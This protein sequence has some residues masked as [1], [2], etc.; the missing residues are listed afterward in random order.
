MCTTFELTTGRPDL[1]WSQVEIIIQQDLRTGA[2]ATGTTDSANPLGA[3]FSLITHERGEIPFSAYDRTITTPLPPQTEIAVYFSK[4]VTKRANTA[5][6]PCHDGADA[7]WLAETLVE[8]DNGTFLD[9]I[10]HRRLFIK[11]KPAWPT[12]TVP[13]L[14]DHKAADMRTNDQRQPASQKNAKSISLFNTEFL[15]S[16]EACGWKVCCMKMAME[17][18]CTCSMDWLLSTG[19]DKCPNETCERVYCS[20]SPVYYGQC[21]MPCIISKFI[22][23][24]SLT[25]GPPDSNLLANTSNFKLFRSENVQVAAEEEIYSLAKLFSEIGGLCSLFIGFSCIFIFEFLEAMLMIRRGNK[26]EEH[27]RKGGEIIEDQISDYCC[28]EE[29]KKIGKGAE[30]ESYSNVT[31]GNHHQDKVPPLPPSSPSTE[32]SVILPVILRSGLITNNQGNG[33]EKLTPA[34]ISSMR[35]DAYLLADSQG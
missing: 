12:N 31:L 7:A 28:A 27:K 29:A 35:D 23:Q 30:V 22:K 4:Y 14:S 20:D 16:R 3:T 32:A 21:P 8:T 6:S 26:T 33:V 11:K 1:R 15:Y 34:E 10:D 17:C 5:R 13:Y 24:N 18:E 2:I 9:F 25:I 19:T